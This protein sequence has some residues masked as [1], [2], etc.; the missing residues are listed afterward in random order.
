MRNTL[1]RFARYPKAQTNDQEEQRSTKVFKIGFSRVVSCWSL[2]FTLSLYFY[3]PNQA[4]GPHRCNPMQ[5]A[6]L[7]QIKTR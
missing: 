4:H 5:A 7:N 2:L 6:T 1:L 3:Y